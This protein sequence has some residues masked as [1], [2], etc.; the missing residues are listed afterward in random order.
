MTT[1]PRLWA[2]LLVLRATESNRCSL[3]NIQTRKDQALRV[4]FFNQIANRNSHLCFSHSTISG[5]W[6]R[7][8]TI[9]DTPE[10]IN[11]CGIGHAMKFPVTWGRNYLLHAQANKIAA[12]F[13]MRKTR[14]S[15]PLRSGF[16]NAIAHQIWAQLLVHS[17]QKRHCLRNIKAGKINY[18]GSTSIM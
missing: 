5:H 12:A 8:I 11:H 14:G 4:G 9:Y 3:R 18:W 6:L 7:N 17:N 13:E 16:Y 10:R 1:S 2:Q 15:Q